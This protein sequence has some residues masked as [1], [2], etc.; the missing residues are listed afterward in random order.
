[1]GISARGTF[2][3]R[4]TKEER[5]TYHGRFVAGG[6]RI[7]G[8][9]KID[10]PGG[11][12]PGC[13]AKGRMRA[14]LVA[15]AT[16]PRPEQPV[17]CER[18]KPEV[19]TVRIDVWTLGA[20]CTAARQLARRWYRRPG[21]HGLPVGGACGVAAHTCTAIASGALHPTATVRCTSGRALDVVELAQPLACGTDMWAI[22]ISCA[23]AMQLET[24]LTTNPPPNDACELG[25]RRAV[26]CSLPGY[27]C[28]VH[29][30]GRDPLVGFLTRSTGW[31]RA[32]ADPHMAFEFGF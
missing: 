21:C 1:V 25:N 31:C 14:Q 15:R 29:Q 8:S 27:R 20:H 11:S 10:L 5:S 32:E 28:R 17:R 26:T 12:T 3:R 2:E 30:G 9:F 6:R 24:T 16:P 18:V 4:S 23:T 22:S 7:A 19:Y 13:A